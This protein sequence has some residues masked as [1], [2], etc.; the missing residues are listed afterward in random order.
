MY[1]VGITGNDWVGETIAD[2]E[3]LL[4]LEYGRIKLVVA[5]PDSYKYK[6]LDSMIA[7]YAKK[8]K[9]LRV[10]SEYLTTASKYIKESKS[11]KKYYGGLLH[12]GK[13]ANIFFL[14][15]LLLGV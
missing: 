5:F 4:D 13:C 6:D 3:Q 15:Q 9:I 10:S 1:D 14:V 7:D 8:K 12:L 2:V 11:Y